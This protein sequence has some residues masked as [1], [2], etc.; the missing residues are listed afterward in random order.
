[1]HT[2]NSS[3]S[4][5]ITGMGETVLDILFRHNQP[6]AAVP[7]G[8]SFNALVSVGRAGLPCRFVGSVGNDHVGALTRTFMQD[9]GIATHLLSTLPQQSVVS[10]AFLD[11]RAEAHYSFYRPAQ[12]QPPTVPQGLSFQAD[13]VLLYGSFYACNPAMRA[14]VRPVLQAARQA[15][16]IV[17]YDLNF[18]PPHAPQLPTLLP[19]IAENMQL[20]TLV[21]ASHDDLQVVYGT[22]DAQA[23]YAQ[24]IGPLCPL[25]VCTSGSGP[26]VVCT[27]HESWTVP[28]PPVEHVVSTI[29]AGDSFVAG[30][31]CGLLWQGVG[32]DAL[33][34]LSRQGW[35]ALLAT[36]TAFAAATCASTDNYVP[37]GFLP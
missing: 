22:H 26:I 27:P 18:R 24:H 33:A 16:A 32:R 10:L 28:V 37:R 34:Q 11:E 1:M 5:T 17:C 14:M 30:L 13:D 2:S 29:G 9:N 36:A 12:A 31:A 7:G 20:S 8:S 25:F 19:L 35:Q 6:V 3:S 23:V 15:G 21:R 4:R